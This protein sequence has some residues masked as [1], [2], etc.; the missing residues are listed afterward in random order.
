[1]LPPYAQA[2][3]RTQLE[4]ARLLLRWE[5]GARSVQCRAEPGRDDAGSWSYLK[6]RSSRARTLDAN[7][8]LLPKPIRQLAKATT[9]PQNQRTPPQPGCFGSSA[10][11]LPARRLARTD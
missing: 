9:P 5:P 11:D 4:L 8:P 2:L 10:G 3:A 6:P 7:A 1:M